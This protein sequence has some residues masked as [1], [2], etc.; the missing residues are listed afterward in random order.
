MRLAT[1]AQAMSNTIAAT[2]LTQVAT[3][4]SLL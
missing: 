4:A 1:L 2:E 3:L